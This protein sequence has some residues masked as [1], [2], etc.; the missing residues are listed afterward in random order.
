MTKLNYL[1]NILVLASL[2]GCDS[3]ESDFY[4]KIDEGQ[5]QVIEKN[6]RNRRDSKDRKIFV[7]ERRLH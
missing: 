2:V 4:S 6:K 3:F 7:I 5:K 1:L